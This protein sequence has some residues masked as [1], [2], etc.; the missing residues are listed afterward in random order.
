[1]NGALQKQHRHAHLGGP[2]GI[3]NAQGL[4]KERVVITE[5]PFDALSLLAAGYE[6]CAIFA[7]DGLR[8]PWVKAPTIAFGFD[9]DQAGDSWRELACQATLLGIE[10]YF[11]PRETYAGFKD[12]NEVWVA[13]KHLAL[14]ERTEA[15][16][17][18]S[19]N[20]SPD[21]HAQPEPQGDPATALN[22]Q[23]IGIKSCAAVCPQYVL[24]E[25]EPE[26]PAFCLYWG[27]GILI[28]DPICRPYKEGLVP[29]ER[30]STLSDF[31]AASP[32]GLAGLEYSQSLKGDKACQDSG[33]DITTSPGEPPVEGR[34]LVKNYKGAGLPS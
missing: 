1:M 8:W 23:V 24:K 3:F 26:S 14:G 10:V 15:Q 11:L 32:Y 13:N 7:V 20:M 29:K 16:P 27:L 31:A 4:T 2:K 5:G 22:D 9:Q 17:E 33:D 6:A 19:P 25:I 28:D 12:L 18:N 30:V 34:H 21:S